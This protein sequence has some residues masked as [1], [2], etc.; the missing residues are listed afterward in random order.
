MLYRRFAQIA[1]ST[2]QANTRLFNTRSLLT[3]GPVGTFPSQVTAHAIR[4]IST[5]ALWKFRPYAASNVGSTI[6]GP[7]TSGIA[8]TSLTL[9][10]APPAQI[11][12]L[13]I[14]V[15]T[16]VGATYMTI[17]AG[18]K[19]ASGGV[20]QHNYFT[21]FLHL[22]LSFLPVPSSQNILA[23]LMF[24]ACWLTASFFAYNMLPE[25]VLKDHVF[26][27]FLVSFLIPLFPLAFTF[28][29]LFNTR[30]YLTL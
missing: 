7:L 30:A 5:A 19:M 20:F 14:T 26:S 23:D 24:T 2:R 15:P 12:Q 29:P 22:V 3:S 9:L 27:L 18:Q 4:P 1:C 8:A 6:L 21:L 16:V 10:V 17:L 25:L 13:A 28:M 11:A